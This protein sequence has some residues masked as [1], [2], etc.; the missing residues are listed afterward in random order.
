MKTL[1]TKSRALVLLIA[2]A[3]LVLV[4]VA[5]LVSPG[6]FYAANN[7]QP[8]S[9]TSLLNELK[10]PAGF[11]LVAGLFM[12]AAIFVAGLTDAALALAAMIYLSYAG[13]RFAS[14]LL[15]GAPAEG[16]V[17]AAVLEA[18]VGLACLAMVALRRP[19]IARM[20]WC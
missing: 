13:S 19:K 3:L 17:Q 1:F 5:I 4:A 8:G 11:L 10:A 9:N 2:G 20:A 18:V 15:D 7:I 14:M 6:E 16:L 12:M